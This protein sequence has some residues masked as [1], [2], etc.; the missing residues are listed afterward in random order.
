MNLHKFVSSYFMGTVWKSSG[1]F[2]YFTYICVFPIGLSLN[3]QANGQGVIY[4]PLC[5]LLVSHMGTRCCCCC[6]FFCDLCFWDHTDCIYD[7][8][9]I[10]LQCTYQLGQ[11]TIK[12]HYSIHQIRSFQFRH[13]MSVKLHTCYL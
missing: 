9:E 4:A 11:V 2:K 8:W 5:R 6:S 7:R 1:L 12:P 13:R 10:D 3:F